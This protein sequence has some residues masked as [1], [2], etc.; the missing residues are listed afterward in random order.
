MGEYLKEKAKAHKVIH[1]FSGKQHFF[2]VESDSGENYDVIVQV[3]CSCKYM[4]VQGS[5]DG[6]I[7]SHIFSVLKEV[8]IKGNINASSLGNL[9]QSKRNACLNLIRPGNRVLNIFRQSLGES[10]DH[11]DKKIEICNRLRDEGKHFV[12]EAIFEDG[13]GRADILCLDN[14]TAYEVVNTESDES[15]E[16]KRRS[17]PEGIKIEVI[18][19]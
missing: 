13:S 1:E 17:Y 10:Q 8:A 2:K 16:K 19:C 11:I 14:F 9:I 18:K 5:K 15:I 4:A 7:C 6:L 12:C 3:K